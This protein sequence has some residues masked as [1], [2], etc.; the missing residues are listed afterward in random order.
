MSS[1]SST[2]PPANLGGAASMKQKKLTFP[3]SKR[4]ASASSTKK[5]AGKLA[6]GKTTLVSNAD[7][8]STEVKEEPRR[9]TI[10]PRSS[11]GSHQS[12]VQQE[13]SN[14]KDQTLES[15]SELNIRDP[16]W[17]KL[18]ADAKAKRNGQ[19]LS[20]FCLK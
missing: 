4:T 9:I 11:S 15:R 3:S 1:S 6:K 18:F 5:I 7:H 17:R 10:T 20:K 13:P 19:P 8:G 2:S 16:R 12:Q 14:D